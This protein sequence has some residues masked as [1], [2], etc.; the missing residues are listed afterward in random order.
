[1]FIFSLEQIQAKTNQ[2]NFEKL[3]T[4]HLLSTKYYESLGLRW[5]TLRPV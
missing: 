5:Y 1:M 3:K 4:Y 2:E